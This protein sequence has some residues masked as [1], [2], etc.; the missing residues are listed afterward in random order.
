MYVYD[1]KIFRNIRFPKEE[2]DFLT[3]FLVLYKEDISIDQPVFE[4]VDAD[5]LPPN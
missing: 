4:I 1:C 5:S 3:A 2:N